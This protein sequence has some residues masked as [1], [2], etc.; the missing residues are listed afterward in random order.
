MQIVSCY[1][2]RGWMRLNLG[3]KHL[4]N[5]AHTTPGFFMPQNYFHKNAICFWKCNMNRVTFVL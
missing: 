1:Y 2:L 5:P 3:K 4:P